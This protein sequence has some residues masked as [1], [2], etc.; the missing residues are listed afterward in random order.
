[1]LDRNRD[2]SEIID[3]PIQEMLVFALLTAPAGDL[4]LNDR[5]NS[6]VKESCFGQIHALLDQTRK[7]IRLADYSQAEQLLNQSLQ[8]RDR[9]AADYFNLLGA[10]HEGQKK[11]RL[12]EKCYVGALEILKAYEPAKSNLQRLIQFRCKGSTDRCIQ[13]GDEISTLWYARS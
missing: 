5:L 8:M 4:M 10:L 11:W 9:E 7:A 13:L 2:I 1:M 3:A 6:S 12:A